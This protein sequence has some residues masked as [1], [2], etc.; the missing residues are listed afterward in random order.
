MTTKLSCSWKWIAVSMF[1]LALF[2]SLTYSW[3]IDEFLIRVLDYTSGLGLWGPFFFLLF[4]ILAAICLLPAFILSLGA[5]L[6][7]GTV[8]GSI[9]VSLSST[10]AAALAFQQAI[11][12]DRSIS[13][14]R[15]V[16]NRGALS[17]LSYY[18]L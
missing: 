7:F 9:L 1:L 12:I 8:F 15:R 13:G 4:Y 11:R 3:N 5:G 6:L 14:Q 18:P 17:P 16:E 10:V 2:I